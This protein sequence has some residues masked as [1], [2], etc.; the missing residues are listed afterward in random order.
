MK[1]TKTNLPSLILEGGTFRTIYTSGVLDAF[2]EHDVHFPYVIGISAGAIN[3]CSYVSKQ[4]ERTYRV[5]K[6]YRNDS[7]Y[8]GVRNFLSDKSYFGLNFSYNI[9]P[10]ELDLFD[11]ET[12]RNFDGVVEFGVTNAYTGKA[13]FM[14]AKEMDEECTLLKATCALPMFFPEIK[15]NGVPYYDGGLA[16]PV[17]VERAEA[18]GYE[19][20]IFVLTR[21]KGYRKELDWQGKV[22]IRSFSKKYPRLAKQMLNRAE[23]YNQTMD[24]IEEL[25][26]KGRALVFRPDYALKSFEKKPDV[27]EQSYLMGFKQGLAKIE[28]VKSFMAQ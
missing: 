25:E 10:N 24:Y 15:L 11:W 16:A 21:P 2:L 1:M 20:H 12:Y 19:R 8:M 23:Q 9:I 13:E 27:F 18:L 28:Q 6:T 4:K 7:R 22:A 17:P 14:D 26:A 5:F 3:A